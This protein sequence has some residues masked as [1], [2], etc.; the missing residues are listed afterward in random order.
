MTPVFSS[1]L[2]GPRSKAGSLRGGG[3]L[4]QHSGCSVMPFEQLFR[5]PGSGP[6]LMFELISRSGLKITE[7]WTYGPSSPELL[8]V[9]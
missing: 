8:H 2:R 6:V 5:G 7:Q 3:S 9:R 1:V 4:R